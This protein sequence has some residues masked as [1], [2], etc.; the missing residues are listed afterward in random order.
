VPEVIA[1]VRPD[2]WNFP[3]FVH[4]L[5]ALTLVGAVVLALTTLVAVRRGGSEAMLKLALG[6]LAY[7]AIPAYIVMRVGAEWIADK[8]GLNADG[9]D[10][11]WINIGY[12]V[13]D[14]A[15]LL[16]LIATILVNIRFRRARRGAESS[17]TLSR[18]AGVLVG[19]TLIGFLVAIWAMTTKPT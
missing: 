10:I 11:T 13:A 17:E 18:V 4:I 7:G 1:A 12:M 2:E 8:E 3:L 9:V 5:G 14:P 19:L 15:F 16:L 6:A